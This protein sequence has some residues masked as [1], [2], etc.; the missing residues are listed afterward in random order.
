[1]A[2]FTPKQ[3]TALFMNSP[4][5]SLLDNIRA[6]IFLEGLVNINNFDCFKKYQLNQAFKNMRTAI[7][8]IPAVSATYG[9]AVVPAVAPVPPVLVSSNG[10]LRLKVASIAN[11]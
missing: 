3:N 6:I 11:H 4:H 9:V 1:M 2:D 5:M 8:E 10:A 7:P